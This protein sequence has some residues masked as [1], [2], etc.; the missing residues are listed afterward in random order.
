MERLEVWRGVQTFVYTLHPPANAPRP[1]KATQRPFR[2]ILWLVSGPA[3]CPAPASSGGPEARRRAWTRLKQGKADHRPNIATALTATGAGT[4]RT[5]E[6]SQPMTTAAPRS[7]MDII[8]PT[9]ALGK[10]QP[11]VLS[12]LNEYFVLF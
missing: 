6:D 12:C 3:G 11:L 9:A 2:Y 7:C 10:L 5:F 8:L 4:L 1:C